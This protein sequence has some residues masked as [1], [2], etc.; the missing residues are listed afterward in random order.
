[1]QTNVA[2]D[3][4]QGTVG[5]FEETTATENTSI[6]ARG[7]KLGYAL[8][9][10]LLSLS[11][12]LTFE[13][14]IFNAH[15]L[16]FTPNTYPLHE[17]A[18]PQNEKYGTKGFLLSRKFP[19][20]VYS[21]L[22][23][24]ADNVFM[25]FQG[26]TQHPCK[27]RVYF[28]DSSSPRR[29]QACEFIVHPGGKENYYTCRLKVKG[30][31]TSLGIEADQASMPQEMLLTEAVINHHPD[32]DISVFRV[33]L[34]T[35]LSACVLLCRRYKWH[36]ISTSALVG[37]TRTLSQLCVPVLALLITWHIFYVLSP[38]NSAQFRVIM[39]GGYIV[40]E[41]S[42]A[43]HELLQPLPE[44][45]E[46]RHADRYTVL[47]RALLHGSLSLELP[48]DPKLVEMENPYSPSQRAE[49]GAKYFYDYSFYKGKYYLYFGLA[50]LLLIYLPVYALTGMI[51]TMALISL[52][53]TT[54]CV[55]S[56]S[57]AL[58]VLFNILIGRCN[59]LLWWGAQLAV[60]S[61]SGLWLYEA[62]LWEYN[63]PVLTSFIFIALML[64]ASWS[65]LASRSPRFQ[66]L[67]LLSCGLLVPLLVLSRPHLLIFALGL[68]A[69]PLWHFLK[70]LPFLATRSEG[71]SSPRLADGSWSAE[72][73]LGADAPRPVK[74]TNAL[75]LLLTPI[76]LGAI[77]IM[78]HNYLR[79]GSVFEFGQKYVLTGFD[80]TYISFAPDLPSLRALLWHF[81]LEPPDFIKNFP[82]IVSP[83]RTYHDFGTRVYL[84]RRISVLSWPLCWGLF[85]I[86]W[87]SLFV[88]DTKA[89]KEQESVLKLFKLSAALTCLA[90]PVVAYIQQHAA[91]YSF[92]Y[93]CELSMPASLIAFVL[94]LRLFRD[95]RPQGTAALAYLVV[96]LLLTKT[97]LMGLLLPFSIDQSDLISYL[98]ADH[99]VL[100]YRIL[101]PLSF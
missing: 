17:I 8:F 86:F 56:L 67:C 75:F 57:L 26:A 70:G 61:C 6:A 9:V 24:N 39:P 20:V 92:R 22:N 11:V 96:G 72:R 18:Q 29:E 41:I 47:L 31:L 12:A 43:D 81:F 71:P 28:S 63:Y 82:Y 13:C 76:V 64:S 40:E 42:P 46:L 54:L 79:F 80:Q 52:I 53:L 33:L 44:P 84:E 62:T 74:L 95:I 37:R 85:L 77:L 58:Q 83:E 25:R 48:V 66:R 21:G 94:L 98:N 51:P 101:T 4:K 7:F 88:P 50:P 73:A 60:L 32:L 27:V 15:A 2:N 68:C 5:G 69:P 30:R 91:G 34:L 55:L 93:M 14:L 99:I 49:V 87:R 35:F 65:L 38:S 89:H 10:L 45:S 90:L 59:L 23:L 36:Q 100:L 1:M 78:Y 97:V 19:G 16:F 3:I